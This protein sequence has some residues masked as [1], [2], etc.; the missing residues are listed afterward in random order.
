MRVAAPLGLRSGDEAE[1]RSLA[2]TRRGDA[3][4]ARRARIVLLAAAGLPHTEIAER[5]G[6]SV[7]TV[8]EWRARYASGGIAALKDLPRSGRPRT[9]DEVE[10]VVA[11]VSPPSDRLGVTRWSSRRLASE[12]GVSPA[13]VIEVWQ[14]WGLKPW[15]QQTLK[16]STSPPLDAKICDV[17]GIYLSALGS[18]VVVCVDEK[19]KHHALAGARPVL[20]PEPGN[21]GQAAYGFVPPPQ[22]GLLAALEAA[23]ATVAGLRHP[24]RGRPEFLEF[25]REMAAAWP[26]RKLHVVCDR[27][28]LRQHPQITE[29]LAG[30]ARIT[31]HFTRPGSWFTMVETFFSI[32]ARQPVRHGTFD[33]LED[34]TTKIRQFTAGG[35]KRRAPFM[36]I[37][38]ADEASA[39]TRREETLRSDCYPGRLL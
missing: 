28:G 26:D 29:W 20:P 23:S 13:S 7:P 31:V 30:H 11:T 21:S 34:L 19:S 33:S 37:K 8:R 1:L 22:A 38:A 4:L 5:V 16:F 15:R 32:I 35:G 9:V 17:I 39:A 18:A 25:L 27:C 2:N 6:V 12:L 14:R 10:I 24:P 36:W 3:G